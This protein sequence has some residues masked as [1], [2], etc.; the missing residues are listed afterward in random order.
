[1]GAPD[2]EAGSRAGEAGKAQAPFLK[3]AQV[4]K[5]A[6]AGPRPW[7]PALGYSQP[8]R[9]RPSTA[10]FSLPGAGSSPRPHPLPTQLHP[11][12]LCWC[13]RG[14]SQA[15]GST[16]PPGPGA[17]RA[18]ASA[19]GGGSEGLCGASRPA[20][21]L[22]CV[23]SQG[24]GFQQLGALQQRTVALPGTQPESPLWCWRGDGSEATYGQE[25]PGL[26][27]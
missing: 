2:A 20:L 15:Q 9:P 22:C 8:T 11:P 18:G 25:Q 14:C 26:R 4:I 13:S 17:T 16:N 1:M 12:S 23:W 7:F 3:W 27:L 19:R 5:P 24:F 6:P 10:I 21:R